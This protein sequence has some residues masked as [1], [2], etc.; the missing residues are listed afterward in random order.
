MVFK[1][2]MAKLGKGAAQVDLVLD[3]EE[4]TLGEQVSGELVIQ[5][6]TVP[7]EINGIDI[8]FMMSVHTEKQEQTVLIHRFPF[9]GS[10]QIQP[11]ERKTLPFSY[12][13]P[14]N[15]LLSGYSVSYY[16]VTHL[17]IAG[18]VDSTDRDPV[19]IMPPQRLQ[20]IFTALEQLGFREKYGS[21]SFDGYMQEFEFS[22]TSFLKEEAKELGF[23]AGMEEEGIRLLLE[24]DL[25]SFTGEQE[26]KREV[27]IENRVLDDPGQLVPFLRQVLTE[28]VEHPHSYVHDK[29][30]FYHH[31]RHKLSGI[32]GAVGAFA[33][34][35]IAAEAFQDIVEDGFA[36]DFGEGEESDDVGLFDGLFGGEEDL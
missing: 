12:E 32:T 34:G 27:W 26:L 13:L 1:K 3:Q 15:L 11:G 21:R 10:F 31:F 29:Q 23:V 33:A 18:A 7:Q 35:L 14:K 20:N 28:M 17:D 25:Y 8:D 2:F 16:F 22:P 5:G 30:R 36:A 9:P 6:G 19:L 4:Y 24:M